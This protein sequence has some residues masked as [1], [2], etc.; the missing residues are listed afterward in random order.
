M[1]CKGMDQSH[2]SPGVVNAIINL[3][4]KG[5]IKRL[6]DW[7]MYWFSRSTTEQFSYLSLLSWHH[8]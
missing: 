7:A 3:L 1:W 4:D 6:L 5:L 8:K 2:F